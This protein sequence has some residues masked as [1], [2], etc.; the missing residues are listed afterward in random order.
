[1]VQR[2]RTVSFVLRFLYT[3]ALIGRLRVIKRRKE[4]ME[5]HDVLYLLDNGYE[6]HEIDAMEREE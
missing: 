1:M 5:Q 2:W 3:S 6:K 4:K